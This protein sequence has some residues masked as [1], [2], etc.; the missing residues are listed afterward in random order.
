MDRPAKSLLQRLQEWQEAEKFGVEVSTTFYFSFVSALQ[1][2]LSEDNVDHVYED[3][4]VDSEGKFSLTPRIAVVAAKETVQSKPITERK[5][6]TPERLKSLIDSGRTPEPVHRQP[7][8]N[9]E[10]VKVA[11]CCWLCVWATL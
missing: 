1:T 11:C 7:I 10:S 8:K 4:Y 9:I 3:S 6:H 5:I 2:S